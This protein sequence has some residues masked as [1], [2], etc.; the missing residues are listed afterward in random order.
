MGRRTLVLNIDRDNDFGEKAGIASPIQGRRN[1][2]KAAVALGLSDPE[3]SDTNSIFAAIKL[4]DELLEAEGDQVYIATLC[5]HRDASRKADREI[6]IQ[7]ESVLEQTDPDG[8][9]FVT[10]GAE[11]EAV[12]PIVRSRVPVDHVRKVVVRQ[13]KNIESTI[14]IIGKALQD[15]KIQHKFLTPIAI[16]AIIFGLFFIIGLPAMGFGAMFIIV[17]LYLIIKI[18]HLEEPLRVATSD[19]A[20]A[21]KEGRTLYLL[22][23][24]FALTVLAFGMVIAYEEFLMADG[25]AGVYDVWYRTIVA[26]RSSLNIFLFSAFIILLGKTLDVY[27]RKGTIPYGVLPSMLGLIAA[28][29]LV[30]ALLLAFEGRLVVDS[31]P[32]L[33]NIFISITLGALIGAFAVYFQRYLKERYGKVPRRSG[34]SWRR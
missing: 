30:F 33:Q 28:Y 19:V 24:V 15:E 22:F 27:I 14:Y 9:F 3:D 29:F 21:L 1:N 7:L 34:A 16:A 25:A 32:N 10:D 12:M 6:V 17:G 31:E 8:V 4:Y 11:D 18:A 23:S 26:L 20:L 13:E 5:G 2:L